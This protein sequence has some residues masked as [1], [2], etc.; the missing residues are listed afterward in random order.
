MFLRGLG[1]C[2][3]HVNPLDEATF[4]LFEAGVL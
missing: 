1:S 3:N 4:Q 2:C